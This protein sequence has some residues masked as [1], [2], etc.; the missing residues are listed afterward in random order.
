[1][2]PFDVKYEIERL[3]SHHEVAVAALRDQIDV[4]LNHD[5]DPANTEIY[6]ATEFRL[7]LIMSL[8]RFALENWEEY[9]ANMT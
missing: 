6:Q 1:M 2:K 3:V 8:G 5:S 9:C 7:F 4:S